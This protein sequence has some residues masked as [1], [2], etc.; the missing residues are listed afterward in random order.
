MANFDDPL[1]FIE[2]KFGH[3]GQTWVML[4]PG[5]PKLLTVTKSFSSK[6]YRISQDILGLCSTDKI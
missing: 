2:G 5:E 6:C 4:S 3:G 1:C